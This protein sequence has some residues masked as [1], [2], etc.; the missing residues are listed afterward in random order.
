MPSRRAITVEILGNARGLMGSFKD[1]E[2]AGKRFGNSMNGLK[3]AI[4]TL[5]LGALGAEAFSFGKGA[6]QAAEESRKVQKGIEA[7]I[8][9]TGGAAGVTAKQID[10][11]ANKMQFKTGID[12]EAIKTSQGLLL[13]FKAVKNEAGKGNDIFDQASVAMIDLGKKMGSTDGAA[14][15]LGRALSDPIGGIRGLKA[16]GVTLTEAQKEQIK[17][18]IKSGDTLSAQKV[19]LAEVQGRVGGFAEK[20]ASAGDKMKVAFD[21]VKE[22]VGGALLPI[23]DKVAE[24]VANKLIPAVERFFK[25]NGP[26]IKKIFGEIKE[27]VE[28]LVKAIGEK[29]GHAFKALGEFASKNK[30]AVAAF[31]GVLVAAAAIAGIVALAGAIAS[32]FNPVVLIVIGIAALIAA[33]VFLYNKFEVVRKIVKVIKNAWEIEFKIIVAIVKFAFNLIK[34]GISEFVDIVKGLWSIFGDDIKKVWQ[35]IWDYLSAA[36]D[37]FKD[38]FTGKWSKLGDDI[39]G[40]LGGLGEIVSGIFGG[41][42]DGAM[43]ALRTGWNFFARGVNVLL[44]D[45]KSIPGFGWVPLLPIWLDDETRQVIAN[46]NATKNLGNGTAP[47]TKVNKGWAGFAVGGIVTGPTHALIGEAGPEA[48]IPLS[49]LGSLTGGNT[50][51]INVQVSPLSNPAEVGQAVVSALKAYE[52]RSG[53]LPLRV[54]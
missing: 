28:P 10:E 38:L 19:I 26:K 29:L 11:F 47:S 41:I 5:G 39:K 51:N 20:T 35:G 25:E 12:D 16:A 21:E 32:L 43:A 34:D 9:A 45:I 54:A 6:L 36:F 53:P 1:A 3:G 31:I 44:R 14:K 49:R 2:G 17:G 24:T 46:D 8:K 30:P 27:K 22:K 13:G 4:T 15:A 33:F 42:F 40:M 48:V 37:F 18:F 52:R 23:F 50:V 7:T